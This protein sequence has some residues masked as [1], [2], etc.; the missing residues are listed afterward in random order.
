M[1]KFDSA[2]ES[3]ILRLYRQKKSSVKVAKRLQI[4]STSVLRVLHRH[5][6]SPPAHGSED[7]RKR[8]RRFSDAQA[9]VVVREYENGESMQSLCRRHRCSAQA[10]RNAVLRAGGKIRPIG[11]ENRIRKW[12]DEEKR[13]IC[14]L[15]ARGWTQTNIAIRFHA[16]QSKI[17]KI[18]VAAGAQVRPQWAR[19]ERHGSWNGGRTRMGGGY[20]GVLVDRLDPLFCMARANNYVPEHRLVMARSLGRPLSKTESVH[21]INGDKHDNRLENLQ[22][23]QGHHGSGTVMRCAHCGSYD[24]SRVP[25]A[26]APSASHGG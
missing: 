21:H 11:G 24:V 4:G 7:S 9:A 22:L 2:F 23:R 13:E 25:I 8:L 10:I 18:L 6:I 16:I 12:S 15:Y 3:L 17:S 20:V 1:Q 26:D 19:G 5:G 14:D